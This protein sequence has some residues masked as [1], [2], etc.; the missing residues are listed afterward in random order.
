MHLRNFDLNLLVV[1]EALWEYR[2][3][4]KAANSLN[5]TQPT[6]SA[7]LTRL[8]TYFNDSLFVWDGRAMIPTNKAEAL[9]PLIRDVLGRSNALIEQLKYDPMSAQRTFVIATADYVSATIAGYVQKKA[10]L[11]APNIRVD[12]INMRPEMVTKTNSSD[13]E[14]YA[15]PEKALPNYQF[16]YSR[17]FEDNYRVVCSRKNK[18]FGTKISF[19]EFLNA[20]QISYSAGPRRVINHET[21]AFTSKN[22]SPNNKILITSYLA[23]PQL[24]NDSECLAVV[25]NTVLTINE[26]HK[27]LREIHCQFDLPSLEVG[28]YWDPIH[29]DDIQHKW[30]RETVIEA[31]HYYTQKHQDDL[32][33]WHKS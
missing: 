19:D 25:P 29:Q 5:V 23:I 6:I 17:L 26:N 30:L 24:L 7:A 13:V 28:I 15:F 31:N 3:A 22:Q 11:A 1:F 14:I 32:L 33:D 9:E 27:H 16:R 4:S 12:F 10:M 20:P 21:L 8:R 18:K 2:S